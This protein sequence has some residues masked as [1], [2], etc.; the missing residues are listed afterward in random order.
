MENLSSNQENLL[1]KGLD[2]QGVIVKNNKKYAVF[3]LL[4]FIKFKEFDNTIYGYDADFIIRLQ[5]LY[6]EKGLESRITF[7]KKDFAVIVL[8]QSRG[9][10]YDLHGID[11]GILGQ[12]FLREQGYYIADNRDSYKFY[13]TDRKIEIEVYKLRKTDGESDI[14]KKIRKEIQE[15]EEIIRKI[16]MSE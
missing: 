12:N 16:W 2:Y 13:M 5:E 1:K 4:P 11:F 14:L 6:V 8:T 15:E 3:T 7:F 9:N 10:K